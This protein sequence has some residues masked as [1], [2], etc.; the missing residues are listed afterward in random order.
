M[1]GV[2]IINVINFL[3]QIFIHKGHSQPYKENLFIK[4]FELIPY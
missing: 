1:V 4:S 2:F 3:Y